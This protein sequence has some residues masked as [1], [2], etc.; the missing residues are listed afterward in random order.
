MRSMSADIG[1][2]STPLTRRFAPPSPGGRGLR[3][4]RA[5]SL[6]RRWPAGPDEGLR[7]IDLRDVGEVVILIEARCTLPPDEIHFVAEAAVVEIDLRLLA[8]F[9]LHIQGHHRTA[10]AACGEIDGRRRA[11]DSCELGLRR[12]ESVAVGLAEIGAVGARIAAERNQVSELRGAEIENVR[13]A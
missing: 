6:G 13:L 4:S 2:D 1:G 5:F 12:R 11:D 9:H 3:L 8:G 7:E 10:R